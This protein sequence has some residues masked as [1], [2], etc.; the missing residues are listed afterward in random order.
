MMGNDVG[1]DSL[2]DTVFRSC[3]QV[4]PPIHHRQSHTCAYFFVRPPRLEHY[5]AVLLAIE[6]DTE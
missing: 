1:S 4:A 5:E 2:S 6:S 3:D